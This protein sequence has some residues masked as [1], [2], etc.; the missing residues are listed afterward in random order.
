MEAEGLVYKRRGAGTFVADAASPLARREQRRILIQRA[1]ALLAE[2][3][4]LNFTFEEVVELL[5]SR[6]RVL[7]ITISKE[8]SRVDKCG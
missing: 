5:R 2:P 7:N 6:P 8:S 3:R 1:N 4:Q